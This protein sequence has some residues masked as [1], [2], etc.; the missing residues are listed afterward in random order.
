LV[1]D[2][3]F[4][5]NRSR[6]AS[7]LYCGNALDSTNV[8]ISKC[9]F[10]RNTSL[11]ST[12]YISNSSPIVQQCFFSTNEGSS[13]LFVYGIDGGDARPVIS[14]NI[15]TEFRIGDR[16]FI[17]VDSEFGSTTTTVSNCTFSAQ[18]TARVHVRDNSGMSNLIIRNSILNN[19]EVTRGANESTTLDVSHSVIKNEECPSMVNCGN[20]MYYNQEIALTDYSEPIPG[21][22][23]I[24]MGTH[25]GI[26]IPLLDY[27]GQQRIRN[28]RIDLGA[29]EYRAPCPTTLVLDKMLSPF[30]GQSILRGTWDATDSI[31]VKAGF[32][33]SDEIYL[34]LNAPN[35]EFEGSFE[36]MNMSD[37][38]VTSEACDR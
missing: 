10:S 34:N 1:E 9:F 8:V 37:L 32:A 6:T 23:A 21:S 30:D 12:L 38:E 11:F 15:F 2:C 13:T 16:R 29:V 28:N 4:R 25:V 31:I 18:D 19:V 22:L 36:K 26:D 33:M 35:I 7:A 5:R 14:N 17:D 24:D 27:R 3:E 20:V